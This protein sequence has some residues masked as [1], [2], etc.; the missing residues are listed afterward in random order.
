VQ[1]GQEKGD[2]DAAGRACDGEA[3]GSREQAYEISSH[4][5]AGDYDDQPVCSG[6]WL[7]TSIFQWVNVYVSREKIYEIQ[8]PTAIMPWPESTTLLRKI[9]FIIMLANKGDNMRRGLRYD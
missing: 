8:I 1:P 6:E 7:L 2:S 4:L 5:R 3:V 9:L